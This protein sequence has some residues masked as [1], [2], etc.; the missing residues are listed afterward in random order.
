MPELRGLSGRDGAV[1]DFLV[2]SALVRQMDQQLG[3][4][5]AA[6]LPCF[7]RENRAYLS[8][9]IGCTGGRH[10]SVYLV[11]RLARRFAGDF[12]GLIV[13]HRELNE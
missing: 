7:E 4:F 10:R 11:E 9:A 6:W 8:V 13:R 3:D 12:P 2:A 5:L 1:I